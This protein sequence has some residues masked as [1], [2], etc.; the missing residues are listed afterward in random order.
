MGKRDTIHCGWFCGYTWRNDKWYTKLPTLLCCLY[1]MYIIYECG[2]GLQVGDPC[3]GVLQFTLI[4]VSFR[5]CSHSYIQLCL[6][7]LSAVCF[8]LDL[9]SEYFTSCIIKIQIILVFCVVVT[10]SYAVKVN[11]NNAVCGDDMRPWTVRLFVIK[12]GHLHY[13][14]SCNSA[15]QVRDS[16][17]KQVLS[18]AEN[19]YFPVR[20]IS[21]VK[22]FGKHRCGKTSS[23]SLA[24]PI[25]S[26]TDPR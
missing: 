24:I 26:R 23:R 14:L 10:I 12:V 3:L 7:N 18:T 19:G 13:S 1:S 5:V 2:R 15:F 8:D 9:I 4:A 16:I 11:G 21:N 20:Y 17:M 22:D 25:L 6:C